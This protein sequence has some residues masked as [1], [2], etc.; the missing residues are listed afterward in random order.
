VVVTGLAVVLKIESEC[1]GPTRRIAV[2]TLCALMALLFVLSLVIPF[3]R[4]FYELTQPSAKGIAAWAI[5][6]VIGVA[7]MLLALRIFR[8]FVTTPGD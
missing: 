5:G 2:A 6:S 7:G 3:L 1:A 8:G 4:H